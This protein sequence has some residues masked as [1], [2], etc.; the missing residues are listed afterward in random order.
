MFCKI[1]IVGANGSGKTTLGK[2]LSSEL[3]YKHMDIEDYCFKKSDIPYS[4]QRTRE[5]F[6]PL[7]LADIQ[8]YE[9]FIF[10]TANCDF[11]DEIN[12]FYDLI[13]YLKAPLD[14]RLERVKKRTFDLHGS[15]VLEG[16]D[17]FEQEQAFFRYVETRSMDKTDKF[18]M[19]TKLP[20]LYIDS[21]KNADDYFERVKSVIT[22]GKI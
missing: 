12:S 15:R 20:V 16:G 21:S 19:N 13:I 22:S 2:R 14:I 8:K 9:N 17:M 18:T 1:A 4:K 7:L 11:G 5:E 10:T 6:T 3:E